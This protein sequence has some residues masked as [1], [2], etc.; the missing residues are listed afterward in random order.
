MAT[1]TEVTLTPRDWGRWLLGLA[2]QSILLITGAYAVIN[3]RLTTVEV[4]LRSHRELQSRDIRDLTSRF[5]DLK[6]ELVDMR[7]ERRAAP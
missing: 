7:K 5:T 1:G 3:S 4:E 2:A 6:D